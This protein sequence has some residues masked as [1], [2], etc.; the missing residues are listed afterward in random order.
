MLPEIHKI[1]I[2]LVTV[3]T[4]MNKYIL[5]SKSKE[6]NFSQK[7]QIFVPIFFGAFYTI[8]YF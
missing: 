1:L 8:L 4:I 7:P 3:N 2:V 6:I 5:K